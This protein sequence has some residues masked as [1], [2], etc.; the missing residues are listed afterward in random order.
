MHV[1]DVAG[2]ALSAIY[3][4][5][6]AKLQ[7]A[8]DIE[9]DIVYTEDTRQWLDTAVITALPTISVAGVKQGGCTD[10]EYIYQ[11]SGDSSNYTYMQIIKYKI[12][13]GT[14]TVKRFDGT[15]NFGHA[16]DMTYNPKTGYLYVCTML[17]DGSI[18]VLNANDLSY[19]ETIYIKNYEGNAYRVWQFCYDR[20][21]DV[22]YSSCGAT[23]WDPTSVCVYD[24]NW[25]C[26]EQRGLANIPSATMQGSETDGTYYYRILYNP[27]IINVVDLTTG[28][29][30][31]NITNPVTREPEAIMY[32]WNGNYY[33]SGYNTPSLFYRLKMFEGGNS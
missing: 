8:Y 28:E 21:L 17:E 3:D 4:R 24:A 13:D 15:P 6:G 22:Y 10:G 20:N 11:C 29:L 33:F 1:Y 30:V 26:L 32:D 23:E 5:S 31:K 12:S 18:I 19:V 14:Y 16:N 25:E 27:N 7:K 2:T 9:G